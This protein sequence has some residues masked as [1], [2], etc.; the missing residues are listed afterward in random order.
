MAALSS[1]CC[2]SLGFLVGT[3]TLY[4]FMT[5]V[6]FERKFS[7]QL[8]SQ[9]LSTAGQWGGENQ[10]WRVDGSALIS[11]RHPHLQGEDSRVADQLYKKVRILC[12][13]MTGPDNL[14]TKAR[15]VKATW[16]RHCNMVIFMSSRED[17]DFPTVGLG[18]KEGR[19]QLYWKT[20]RAFQ[21]VEQHHSH[22]ADWFLK[23]DDD[24]FVVID[25]L[26]WILSNYTAD[27]P[28]YFGKRFKP[29]TKQ[30]YMSG[31]AG[32]VLSREAL[33]RFVEGFR[34][35]A[36]THTTSVEDLALGQCLEKMGVLAGDSRDSIHRETFHPFVPEHHLTMKFA[37]SFWYWNYCYYPI[38]EGPQCCSD[39]AV[40][41]HY[42]D[43]E[44]MY[45]LEYYTYHLRAYG[46]QYRYQPSLPEGVEPD[47]ARTEHS[48]LGAERD[49][50]GNGTSK[51]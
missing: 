2:F 35:K 7:L 24:T 6:W 45:M 32:Y 31:G 10:S 19:D 30:G 39:L 4:F 38:V 1:R 8:D 23:A 48:P 9:V 3:C 25:N 47:S 43:A 51:L 41:F 15:H 26:R 16:S 21:Y 44:L 40:S 12:W 13:V 50:P 37:K 18:T 34:T 20:I 36:C 14:E 49:A 27:E 28:I 29:Y 33:R 5:Q 46:Y 42:V 22:Q 11:L 17:P